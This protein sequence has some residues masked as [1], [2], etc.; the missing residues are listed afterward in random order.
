[1]TR[2]KMNPITIARARGYIRR[3]RGYQ[4]INDAWVCASC[5]KIVKTGE[6]DKLMRRHGSCTIQ[7][8]IALILV[9]D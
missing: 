3:P 1:M 4:G 2:E 5:G 8:A 7:H 9:E 6:V